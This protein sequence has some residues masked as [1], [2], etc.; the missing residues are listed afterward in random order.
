MFQIF[1]VYSFVKYKF[2]RTT[3]LLYKWVF[4]WFIQILKWNIGA[5][6]VYNW[7]SIFWIYLYPYGLYHFDYPVHRLAH[8]KASCQNHS[9]ARQYL[10]SQSIPTDPIDFGQWFRHCAIGPGALASI[11]GTLF[12]P[13]CYY[14]GLTLSRLFSLPYYWYFKGHL[15]NFFCQNWV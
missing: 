15:V 12:R 7:S 1:S 8:H 2:D 4:F 14:R 10:Q 9:H 6:T 5:I 3:K 11:I 13:F